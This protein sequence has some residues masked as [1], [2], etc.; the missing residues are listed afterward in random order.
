MGTIVSQRSVAP[1]IR[2]ES[3]GDASRVM[4]EDRTTASRVQQLLAVLVVLLVVAGVGG[5]MVACTQ[6]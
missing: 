6:G 2:L 3:G 4:G 5:L 1:I